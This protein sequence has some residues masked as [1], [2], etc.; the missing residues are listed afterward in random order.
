MKDMRKSILV[1][2]I[3][4]LA[5]STLSM[6]LF[7]VAATTTGPFNILPANAD[8]DEKRS[9]VWESEDMNI[10]VSTS[11][12]KKDECKGIQVN[13]EARDLCNDL[14]DSKCKVAHD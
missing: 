13:K 10:G 3:T 9:Q 14:S 5:V 1:G 4:T 7:V 11:C 2:V 12:E 6:S 8:R